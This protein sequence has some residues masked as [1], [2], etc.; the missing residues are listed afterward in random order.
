MKEREESV[1]ERERGRKTDTEGVIEKK[2]RKKERGRASDS[3]K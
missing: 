3:L 2:E 1:C